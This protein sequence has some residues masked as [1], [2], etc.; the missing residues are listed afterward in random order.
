VRR[1][2]I[3]NRGEIALRTVRVCRRSLAKLIVCGPDYASGVD[4]A[5]SALERFQVSGVTTAAS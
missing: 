3:V 1:V 5:R 2:L 4:T